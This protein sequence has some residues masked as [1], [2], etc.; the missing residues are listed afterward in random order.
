MAQRGRVAE[1]EGQVAALQRQL[2]AAAAQQEALEG[3]LASSDTAAARA[4]A[5][6]GHLGAA[7]GVAGLAF[8][9]RNG[10]R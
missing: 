1:L 5:E 10:G 4:L 8:V 7:V 2:A 6:V 3:R 9:W